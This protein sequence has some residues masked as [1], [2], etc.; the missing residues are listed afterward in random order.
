M[1]GSRL[2][3]YYNYLRKSEILF[4]QTFQKV[5]VVKI[6]STSMTKTYI[7]KYSTIV[8]KSLL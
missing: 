7:F 1:N 3:T 8:I 6:S 2:M 5:P 4:K